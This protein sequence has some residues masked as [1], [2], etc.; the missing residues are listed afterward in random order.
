MKMAEKMMSVVGHKVRMV[1]R[2]GVE[3]N[4]RVVGFTPYYDNEEDDEAGYNSLDLNVTNSNGEIARYEMRESEISS[5][6]VI[7]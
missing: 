3:W 4:G 6:E 7:D 2:D 1:D 5:I